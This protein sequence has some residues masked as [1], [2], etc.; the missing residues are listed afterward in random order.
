[1]GG[2]GVVIVID[3][4]WCGIVATGNVGLRWVLES[5]AWMVYAR[6]GDVRLHKYIVDVVATALNLYSC[7]LGRKL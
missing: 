5:W 7:N 1:M 2:G 3:C 6:D 4:V